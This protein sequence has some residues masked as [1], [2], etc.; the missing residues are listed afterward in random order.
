MGIRLALLGLVCVLSIA[1]V[2]NLLSSNQ[3]MNSS[4]DRLHLV[5]TYG[6]FGSVGN[7]RYEIVV[8]GTDHIDPRSSGARWREYRFHGKPGDPKRRPPFFS[9]YH[10]RIDWEIWFAAFG[11]MKR[12]LWPAYF[13]ARLL[14]NE[15]SVLALLRENP[16]PDAPVR[17]IRMNR[18]VYRFTTPEERAATGAWWVREFDQVFLGRMSLDHP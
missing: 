15:P 7:V 2:T 3:R 16:F 6:A 5:N 11:S 12:E 10:H 9:P 13:A 18:Y 8:E 17:A 14:Q 4:F 1:V